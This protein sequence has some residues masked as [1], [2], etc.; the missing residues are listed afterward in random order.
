MKIA[1]WNEKVSAMLDDLCMENNVRYCNRDDGVVFC[2]E[3]GTWLLF[4]PGSVVLSVHGDKNCVSALSAH[5][6]NA[7]NSDG[8]LAQE[9]VSG[10]LNGMKCRKFS[11][12]NTEVYAREK[13]LR[14][15]PKNTLF[16][17]QGMT[18]PIVAGIWENDRLTVIGFVLPVLPRTSFEVA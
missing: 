17:V 9:N 7:L 4:S 15:F 6:E 2:D 14:I 12:G 1:K 11:D 3:L 13:F 16:Y 10:W 5:W 8:R 18:K